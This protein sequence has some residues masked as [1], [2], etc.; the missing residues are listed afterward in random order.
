MHKSPHGFDPIPQE[1]PVMFIFNEKVSD[2]KVKSCP[3]S[4]DKLMYVWYTIVS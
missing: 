3:L 1:I 4:I 2:Q